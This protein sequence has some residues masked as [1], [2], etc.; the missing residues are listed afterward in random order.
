MGTLS[1]IV[2]LATLVAYTLHAPLLDSAVD[3]V[4]H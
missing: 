1:N 4:M 3:H 2:S